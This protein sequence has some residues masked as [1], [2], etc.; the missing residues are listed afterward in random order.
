[1][2]AKTQLTLTKYNTALESSKTEITL[3][4]SENDHVIIITYT[5]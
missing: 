3:L 1:M 2:T 4:F 5:S